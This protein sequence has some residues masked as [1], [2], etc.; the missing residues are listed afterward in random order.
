[1]V[2]GARLERALRPHVESGA[3]PGLAWTVARGGQVCSGAAGRLDVAG[4]VPV[5]EDS[6][7]RISS[8]T[9]PITAVAALTL[10][11]GG[12]LRIDDPVDDLL[13]ELADR[14]V[15]A[16]P[17]GPLERTVPAHRPI[18]LRDLLTFRLGLGMDFSGAPQPAMRA[19]VERGLPFGPP[20]PADGVPGDE[21]LRILGS[22]PLEHQPGE[23]WLYHVGADVLGVLIA[24]AA[25][26]SLGT[27]LAER[28]FAPLGM[29][30]TGF[31]VPSGDLDRFGPQYWSPEGERVVFDPTD[32]QWSTPPPFESGGAGLVS[33]LADLRAFGRM[34]LR[35][36][37]GVLTAATIAEMTRNHLTPGQFADG[38][39]AEEGWGLGV[40]VQ[41]RD[42]SRPAG[43]YGWDGGL[44]TCW[45]N[46]PA[47]GTTAVLLTN[48][49]WSSPVRP[50]VAT[51]FLAAALG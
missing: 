15:L 3:V 36:G 8:T 23:R 44:G 27:V 41:V 38:P 11:E 19:A 50:A 21:Y 28:V 42:G 16:E 10:V 7:F 26:T 5:R 18:S 2:D 1:M 39:D 30:G 22:V 20:S 4:D 13:P 45:T 17:G 29:T 35:G 32:G 12:T 40:G 47:S 24:R 6:I 34:L 48:E 9:K 25:G 33:T 14:Q 37:D 43:A 51:D 31:V 46:D 49:A